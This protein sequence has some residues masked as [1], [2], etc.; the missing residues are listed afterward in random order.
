MY[1]AILLG[2]KR[3]GHGFH[4]AFHPE[5]IKMVKEKDICV[6]CCPV[7]NFGLGYALDL[8]THPTRSLLHQ[9]VAVSISPD[10]PGFFDYVGVTLDYLY[11]FIAW[12]LDIADLMKLCQNSLKYSSVNEEEKAN[13]SDF[14]KYKW[15]RFLDYVICKF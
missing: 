14:F 3:I 1:D 6:E 11:V 8:R 4:L 9:G 12:D 13:L 7:S 5:L 10:D 15:D 2:T